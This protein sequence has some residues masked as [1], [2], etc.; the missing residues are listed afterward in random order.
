MATLRLCELMEKDVISLENGELLG[1]VGDVELDIA[2]QCVTAIIIYGRLKF[3][4]LFG[5]CDDI[6]VCWKDIEL[7]GEDAILVKKSVCKNIPR[8]SK[9]K[10]IF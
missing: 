4:G 8:K 9:K 1:R 3:F 2:K 5:K 10:S 6:Y 7:I